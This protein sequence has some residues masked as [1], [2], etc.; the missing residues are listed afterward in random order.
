MLRLARSVLNFF[1]WS[2]DAADRL[3]FAEVLTANEVFSARMEETY[4]LLGCDPS[5]TTLLEK[6]LQDYYTRILKKLKDVG[7]QS[8][9]GDFY[10]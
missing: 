9:Q 5:D 1:Q 4:K 6:Y 10:L 7:G 2:G 8:R 3:A